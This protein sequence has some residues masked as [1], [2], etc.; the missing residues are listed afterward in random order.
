VVVEE[1]ID[2]TQNIRSAEDLKFL[3]FSAITDEGYENAVFA[4]AKDRRLSSIPWSRFPD[5]YLDNYTSQQWDRIDP[6]VQH[7]QRAKRPFFWSDTYVLGKL[8][9]EQ[10]TFF[11]ECRE[12]GVHS[13]ITFPIH[14]PGSE[15]DLVSVS[16]RNERSAPVHRIPHLH[17]ITAQYVLRYS[18]LVENRRSEIPTLTSKENECLRWCKEGK[19][20]WEIGE[21]L[22]ISEK[23]VEFHMSNVMRK[24]GTNNRI[25]A[26][27]IGIQ[28]GLVQL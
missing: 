1:F 21:I 18:E 8:S 10:K 12:L 20:N 22:R 2:K 28:R 3:F 23:T 26:V 11:A 6:V 13:G 25:S 5:G 14:G 24:L 7:I 27:V 16:L 17:M 4:R 19:T 15:V 9:K